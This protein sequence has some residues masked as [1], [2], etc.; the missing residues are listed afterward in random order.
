MFAI[1]IF[2]V[3]D[4]RQLDTHVEDGSATDN[5]SYEQIAVN[6]REEVGAGPWDSHNYCIGVERPVAA[7]SE[8]A[9]GPQGPEGLSPPR[10]REHS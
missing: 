9:L 10:E 5:L 4:F 6:D 8:L 7:V 3:S 1:E 2:A